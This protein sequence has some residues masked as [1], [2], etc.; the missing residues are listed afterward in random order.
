MSN[1][2]SPVF[3]D[4]STVCD[5]EGIVFT[6]PDFEKAE[7]VRDVLTLHIKI[8]VRLILDSGS[9]GKD[10]PYELDVQRGARII[11]F[12]QKYTCDRARCILIICIH[13]WISALDNKDCPW[14][15][16]APSV[17]VLGPMLDEV[18]LCR[19]AIANGVARWKGVSRPQGKPTECPS[20]QNFRPEISSSSPAHICVHSYV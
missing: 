8:S 1:A 9:S 4:A 6:D 20:W 15:D 19:N 14:M 11:R 3:K 10:D 17:F 5:D 2:T 16:A 7:T 12:L 13:K 18:E